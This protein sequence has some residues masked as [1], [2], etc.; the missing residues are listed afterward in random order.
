MLPEYALYEDGQADAKG[1]AYDKNTGTFCTAVPSPV[2]KIYQEY[3]T[4]ESDLVAGAG[5]APAT[6]RLCMPLRLSPL[7]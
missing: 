5:I 6:S 7:H 1:I 3:K 4:T 2:F